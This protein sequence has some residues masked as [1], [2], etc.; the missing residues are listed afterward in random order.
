MYVRGVSRIFLLGGGQPVKW[1][2]EPIFLAKNCMKMKEFGPPGWRASLAP[3]LDPSM[4]VLTDSLDTDETVE[5]ATYYHPQRSWGNVMFLHVSVILFTGGVG[6]PHCMLGYVLP[7]TRG[8]HPAPAADTTTPR[9]E[10]GTHP[11]WSR[12]PPPAQCMLGD[13]G[14]K[15]AVRILLECN[16]VGRSFHR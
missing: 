5:L 3:R 1:V 9:P 8:R 14:N 7:R 12:T 10:A 2:Y 16:L 11:P 15:L 13:T 6:L 4:A